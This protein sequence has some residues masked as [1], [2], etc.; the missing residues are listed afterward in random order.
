MPLYTATDGRCNTK[1]G[2]D[3]RKSGRYPPPGAAAAGGLWRDSGIPFVF[4]SNASANVD[5]DV[6]LIHNA[7]LV[8]VEKKT[9]RA[10][11][12]LQIAVP[13]IS[14][15][16]SFALSAQAEEQ[17]P[18]EGQGR[19]APAA[20]PAVAPR[21]GGPQVRGPQGPQG[22]RVVRGNFPTRN[23]GGHPYHGRL[24]WEGGRWRHEMHNGRFGYWWDVGGVWYF[25]PQPMDGP[26]TYVSDV[27]VM[28]DAYADGP[29]GPD[30]PDGGPGG[31]P[32]GGGY[33]P[34]PVAY[35][36]PPPPP[37]PD[38]AA[39]AVGGAVIG[40]VLGGLITG[41]PVGAAVGA[42]AGGTAGAIAGAQAAARPGYYLAQGN[43]Y[44]KYPSGQYV[45]VDPR[46]C[47]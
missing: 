34:P 25:Y 36:P 7:V 35:A 20:R 33:P 24:A 19:P 8:A 12:R 29:D 1:I 47:Y 9:M 26:P 40:G 41:R 6:R 15:V 30:G 46:S 39:S 4:V 14:I 22:Q 43:C 21:P 31:P 11:R 17:R 42:I 2:P 45:Q 27:E 37:P 23:F 10:F 18:R 5:F 13:L 44:Y 38:P 28:D 32:V 16:A 3:E